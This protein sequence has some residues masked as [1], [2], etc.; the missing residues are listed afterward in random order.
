M[1]RLRL[2]GIAAL[3]SAAAIVPAAAQISDP[4]LR[5]L[6]NT[7]AEAARFAEDWAAMPASMDALSERALHN[8][9]NG[10]ESR[11]VPFLQYEAA[12]GNADAKAALGLIHLT[13][14]SIHYD[15]QQAFKYNIAAAEAGVPMAQTSVGLQFLNGVGVAEDHHQ[16]LRWFETAATKGHRESAYQT[17]VMYLEGDGVRQDLVTARFWLLRA[18]AQGD[19]RADAL[20][21]QF[22]SF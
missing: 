13:P 6:E 3:I 14:G 7:P 16:A 5:H 20:L 4:V 1:R 11:D 22:S 10:R 15:P 12:Y 18:R 17:G 8:F 2:A 19:R 9:V 21:R